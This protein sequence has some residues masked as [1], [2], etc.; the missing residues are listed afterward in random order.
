MFKINLTK[1]KNITTEEL[2]KNDEALL[3]EI[4]ELGEIVKS[5]QVAIEA[6]KN[7]IE[8]LQELARKDLEAK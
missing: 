1:K 2:Y 7:N 8:L 6:L 4:Y 5:Q 3:K